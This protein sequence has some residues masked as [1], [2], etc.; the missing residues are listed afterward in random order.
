MASTWSDL[1]FELIGTGDQSGTWGATTNDNLGIAIQQAI[2]AGQYRLTSVSQR[3]VL[4][5]SLP[6]KFIQMIFKSQPRAQTAFWVGL[7]FLP[8][9][10]NLPLVQMPYRLL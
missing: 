1:K 3:Q 8:R 9:S 6:T 7:R 10:M 4:M 2:G 5:Q